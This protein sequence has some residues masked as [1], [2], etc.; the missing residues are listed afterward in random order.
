MAKYKSKD[1]PRS[2]L[3]VYESIRRDW[4]DV[5]PYTRVFDDERKKNA[6]EKKHRKNTRDYEQLIED[7]EDGWDE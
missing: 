4:G 2:N 5:K 3:E 7:G 1:Q 6:R